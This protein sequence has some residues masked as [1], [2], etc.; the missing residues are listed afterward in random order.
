MT[1]TNALATART[2]LFVPGNRPERFEKAFQSGADAVVI[3]L[4]DSVPAAA[5]P[6]ARE[7]IAQAWQGLRKYSIPLVIRINS[8][9]QVAGREDLEWLAEL[10]APDAVMV[11]KA[12]SVEALSHVAASAPT[13]AILPLIESAAG[14]AALDSL[15]GAANVLR[16]V[17]GHID[18]M[19]DT[20]LQCSEGEPELMPLRFAVAMATRAHK[21]AP[22]V[23]G[24]TIDI[25][26]DE[27]LRGDTRRALRL[28]FGGKLCIHPHQIAVVHE[29]MSPS[30]AEVAWAERVL[31]ADA[32]SG[33]AAVQLDGRMVDLPVVLQARRTLARV[34]GRLAG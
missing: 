5:K 25:A 17:V 9:D 11:P 16:L 22:A 31:A 4:E 32:A 13:A 20:G 10:K 12:E 1:P 24:V 19:A 6:T 26:N 28:G 2:F 23:D 29:S 21:L 15:A 33:G 27:L 14:Y 30:A 18:F 3:D 34:G 8:A 7:A